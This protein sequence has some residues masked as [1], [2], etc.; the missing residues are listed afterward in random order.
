MKLGA[1]GTAGAMLGN[2]KGQIQPIIKD[3]NKPTTSDYPKVVS[4]WN[5]GL[6]ANKAA[7]DVLKNN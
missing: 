2:T 6:A 4:T 7:W 5:H 3:I 1:L